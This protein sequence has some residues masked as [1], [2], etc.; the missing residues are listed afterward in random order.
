MA[1]LGMG[2]IPG[3][4]PLGG[5]ALERIATVLEGFRSDAAPWPVLARIL[6][7]R[8]RL[9]ADIAEA[10][11][12][13]GRARGLAIWQFMNFVRVQPSGAGLPITRLLDRI[14][15]LVLLADER[16][17]RQ[18]PLAA[19]EIDAVRLMTIHGSKGLEFPSVH[20]LG[21]NKN[22]FPRTSPTPACPPPDGMIEGAAGSG[23]AAIAS[24][25]EEEQECLFYVALSRARDRLFLYSAARTAAN[26]RR[27]PS[28]YLTKVG[29][30]L[31]QRTL[32]PAVTKPPDEDLVPL[33]VRFVGALSFTENQLELYDRCPRRFFYTHILEVGG[34]RTATAFMDMHDV[35]QDVVKRLAARP[36]HEVD[37]EVV[38]EVFAAAFDSHALAAHGYA[39]DFRTIALS[40][41]GY[42][43]E[44]RKGKGSI[45]AETLKLAV[46]GGEIV[47]TPDEVLL[48]D[49]GGRAFRRV[50][51]GHRSPQAINGLAAAAFQ[52]AATDLFPGCRVELVYLADASATPV[53]LK[54][55]VLERRRG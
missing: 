47:V 54:P 40:L 23:L 2:A 43:A 21:L 53:Q 31:I 44:S 41:V 52:L 1:W 10:Q 7:D 22:A 18:L 38:T 28:P 34:R 35:V 8:T 9:A 42:F 49:G 26:A 19:Q 45:P 17:L 51:S 16:D 27:D 46:R 3:L 12:V 5:E 32:T 30:A 39:A 14:R 20:L 29:G 13:A 11:D 25:Q 48:D 33:N 36:P 6:L 55:D 15:R 50:R 24:G 4:T 37:D